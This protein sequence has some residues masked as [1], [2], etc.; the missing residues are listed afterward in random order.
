M[1][2]KFNQVMSKKI[3]KIFLSSLAIYNIF[4]IFIFY[5]FIYS[6]LVMCCN[7]L[8]FNSGYCKDN[9]SCVIINKAQSFL[10]GLY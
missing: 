1:F 5:F 2:K 8:D 7:I 6:I 3:M 4:V 10:N 9:V